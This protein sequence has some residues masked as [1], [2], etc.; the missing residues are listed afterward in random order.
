M[1]ASSLQLRRLVL[2]AVLIALCVIGANVKIMGSIALDS[3]PAFLGAIILGPVAGAVLGVFGHLISA[4]LSGFPLTLPVHLII[5]VFMGACM[6]A[7]GGIRQKM[8]RTK[9]TAILLADL[10][11]Y[12]INVPVELVLLYP[13]LKQAVYA[14]FVPLTLATIANLII[15]EVIYAALAKRFTL[16]FGGK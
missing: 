7:F 14:L 6:F 16:Y 1:T 13:I 9:L 5:A 12:L 11:G 8:G 2:G 3:A 15:C 4:M 10:V